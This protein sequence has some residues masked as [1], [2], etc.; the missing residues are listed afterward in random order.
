MYKKPVFVTGFDED[1]RLTFVSS[2]Y[3]DL[4]L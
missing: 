4:D 3:L 2:F 1:K